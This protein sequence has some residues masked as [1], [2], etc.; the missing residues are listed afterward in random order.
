MF[1]P[2]VDCRFFWGL[3]NGTWVKC[4]KVVSVAICKH[5]G[6]GC[7]P[8]FYNLLLVETFLKF[9]LVSAVST[10]VIV[11][12]LWCMSFFVSMLH[13]NVSHLQVCAILK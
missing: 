1:T 12:E 9:N 6:E 8:N 13:V 10:V 7:N 3:N 4:H 2:E 5:S 11:N